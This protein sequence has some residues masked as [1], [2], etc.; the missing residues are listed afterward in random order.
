MILFLLEKII[1]YHTVWKNLFIKCFLTVVGVVSM[2]LAM[3]RERKVGPC[4]DSPSALTAI[5]LVLEPDSYVKLPETET[6]REELL[7]AREVL[8]RGLPCPSDEQRKTMDAFLLGYTPGINVVLCQIKK[9]EKG[10]RGLEYIEETWGGEQIF[11]RQI[12]I[13]IKKGSPPLSK[14]K[15]KEKE[16]AYKK[17]YITKEEALNWVEKQFQRKADFDR[18]K[19][20][21][22]F[23]WILLRPGQFSEADY[24]HYGK[25]DYIDKW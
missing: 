12:P 18:Y 5:L 1:N 17:G 6:W 24:V 10:E 8:K 19:S 16:N 21:L 13:P 3:M 9:S 23:Y 11:Y 25:G 22:R 14:E 4:D 7:L 15:I 20:L 2:P